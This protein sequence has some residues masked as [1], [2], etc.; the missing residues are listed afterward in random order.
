LNQQRTILSL[1]SGSSSRKVALYRVDGSGE[2]LMVHA[3]AERLET[4][5][6]NLSLTRGGKKTTRALGGRDASAAG[7]LSAIFAELDRLGLPQPDAAGHR[8]VHGGRDRFAPEKVDDHLVGDLKNL[9]AFAP[10]HLPDEIRG[11]EETAARF[12]GLPQVACFDTAFHRTMPEIA[13]RFALPRELY[14]Q[15]IRRYGFHGI[16]YEYIMH[17]LGAA[18]P[19]RIIIAHLGNGASMAAVRDGRA[20]DTTM[21]L[22][23]TGGFMMGTRSGDLDPA[24]AVHLMRRKHLDADA[25]E[26]LVNDQ[27]GLLGV[28]GTSSDMKTLLDRRAA[29]PDAALAVEMFCYQARKHLGALAAALGGVNLIVFTGGIGERAA[30]VRKGICD[31]LGHLGVILDDDRN[32]SNADTLS[33]DGSRCSVRM[34]PTDEDLMIARHT[35]RTIFAPAPGAR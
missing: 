26:R 27:S 35:W 34:I 18:A 15:G 9:I 29:D 8:V 31:G 7:A 5:D 3:N 6:A 19:A 11:I 17:V 25:L 14:A 16:S 24:V 2:Q 28:S 30:A 1:N 33:A 32:R 10:L 21:G 4:A 22:A 13:E 23:P 20:I 12:P